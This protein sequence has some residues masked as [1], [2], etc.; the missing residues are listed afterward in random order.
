MEEVVFVF[1]VNSK[2]SYVVG[3]DSFVFD[4]CLF[5][6]DILIGKEKSISRI[7]EDNVNK[8]SC[9]KLLILGKF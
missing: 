4:R 3:E 1:E 2:C 9:I 5:V 6:E 7:L 8:S